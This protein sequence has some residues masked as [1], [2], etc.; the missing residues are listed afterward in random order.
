MGSIELAAPVDVEGPLVPACMVAG[1]DEDNVVTVIV[2]ILGLSH[3]SRIFGQTC[4]VCQL[5]RMFSS[6][7]C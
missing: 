1:V 3:G 2:T 7:V 5:S 4:I 6:H